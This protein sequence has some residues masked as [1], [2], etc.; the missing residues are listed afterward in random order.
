MPEFLPFYSQTLKIAATPIGMVDQ[1][2]V[3]FVLGV[4]TPPP[5][6]A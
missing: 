2:M 4:P 1:H 5:N 6:F 3:S